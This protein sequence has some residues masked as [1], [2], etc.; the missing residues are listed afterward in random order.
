MSRLRVA[1]AQFTVGSD[2]GANL[3]TCVRMV[4]TA[5]GRGA[6]LIVL[7]AYCN[8]P[9]D[10]ADREHAARVACRLGGEFLETVAA[11]AAEHEVY[12]K[13]HVTLARRG[14]DHRDQPPVRS[15]RRS[16]RPLRRAR[17]DRGPS[18]AGSIPVPGRVRWST[19]RSGGSAMFAGSDGELP[20]LPRQLAVD[21][22]QILLASLNSANRDTR[23]VRSAAENNSAVRAAENRVLGRGGQRRRGEHG[24]RARRRVRGAGA[25]AGGSRGG[26]RASSPAGPTTRPGP[27]AATSSSRGGPACTRPGARRAP[28]RRPPRRRGWRCCARTDMAWPRSRTLAAWCARPPT[29]ASP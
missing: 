19:P 22:A 23:H 26:R 1:A 4:A 8:H 10:Y 18:G 7:P 16:R 29:T 11:A 12:L 5:A 24:L 20:D 21:G 15:L 17:V 25:A 27:T 14:P 28:G 9:V 3:R 2:V 6:Q 13:L